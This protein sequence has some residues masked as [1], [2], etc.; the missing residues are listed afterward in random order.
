MCKVKYINVYQCRLVKINLKLNGSAK[1][2]RPR[3]G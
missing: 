1:S 3:S 2:L